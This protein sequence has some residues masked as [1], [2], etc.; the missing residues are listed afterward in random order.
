MFYRG[1][2][3]PPPQKEKE[4]GGRFFKN[5]FR[6]FFDFWGVGFFFWFKNLSILFSP[7]LFLFKKLLAPFSPLPFC[8]FGGGCGGLPTRYL[9]RLM[10]RLMGQQQ[11]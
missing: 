5:L 2:K 7:S 3:K 9:Q 4:N 8:G 6:F 1:K 11:G 10:S